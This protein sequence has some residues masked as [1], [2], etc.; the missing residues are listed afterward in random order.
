[1]YNGYNRVRR[2]HIGPPSDFRHVEQALPQRRRSFRPLE[3]SICMPNNQ[4]S[5]LLPF[6][7]LEDRTSDFSPTSPTHTRSASALSNFTIPRKAVGSYYSVHGR[8]ESAHTTP[9]SVT[10]EFGRPATHALRP[11]P[12]LPESLSTQELIAALERELPQYPAPAR[13]RANTMPVLNEQVERVKS[14]LQEKD[15]LDRKI[16]D[17]DNMIEE[18]QSLYIKSRPGS[19][20]PTSE[21]TFA[22]PIH[23]SPT[24]IHLHSRRANA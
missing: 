11:R 2:P 5:P 7:D 6:F 1:M 20:Y 16:R 21:G 10:S 22:H 17:L 9:E 13:L 12:S 19:I 8:L 3:L 24:N 23:R 15:E 18:R 4:L 14:V